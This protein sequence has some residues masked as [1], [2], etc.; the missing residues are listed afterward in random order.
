MR[1]PGRILALL[2]SLLVSLSAWAGLPEGETHYEVR[3]KWGLLDTKV[4]NGTFVVSRSQWDGQPALCAR[5]EVGATPFFRLFMA[6]K[7]RCVLY[8][9][10]DG[11]EP[12]YSRAP[13]K[14]KDGPYVFEMFYKR[15]ARRID[16]V[17]VLDQLGI[18]E[19][20]V[21]KLDGRTLD[22]EALFFFF[23]EVD[24]SM[25]PNGNPLSLQMVMP[26]SEAPTLMYYEGIDTEKF[27]GE[28][29]YRYRLELTGRGLMEN[30]SG[31][32][33]YLWISTRESRELL[34]LTVPL[35]NGIMEARLKR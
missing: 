27:P 28:P 1:T 4:A 32:L 22:L 11:N 6:D 16:A 31:N 2:F 8:L 10:Q 21:F 13:G 19:N 15:D 18:T 5:V 23:S 35:N 9:S 12:L 34:L 29:C 17:T 26:R 25:M 14:G 20:R 33:V 24:P 30:R 3:Y 7:Y